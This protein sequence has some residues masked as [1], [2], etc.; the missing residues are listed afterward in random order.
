MQECG[1]VPGVAYVIAHP[2]QPFSLVKTI[3]PISRQLRRHHYGLVVLP[4]ATTTR[5][6]YLNVEF[7]ALP[8][9][10]ERIATYTPDGRWMERDEKQFIRQDLMT[11]L[12]LML[13]EWAD[14]PLLFM[15]LF[16]AQLLRPIRWLR[17]RIENALGLSR[18]PRK[19]MHCISSLGLGGAQRQM[20][21]VMKA[22]GSRYHV[23]LTMLNG[24]DQFFGA[25]LEK[26]RVRSRVLNHGSHAYVISALRLR[27]VLREEQIDVLHTWLPQANVVGALAGFLAGTPCVVTSE[28]NVSSNKLIWYPQWWFRLADALAA[29][30]CTVAST[31]AEAVRD[32]FARYTWTRRESVAVVYNGSQ[33]D[34][35]QILDENARRQMRTDLGISGEEAVVGIFGRLEPEKD[36]GTFLR[37]IQGAAQRVGNL[38]A[39]V[40]GGGSL[41]TQVQALAGEFQVSERVQFLGSRHDATSL[42]QICDLVV[43]T[44][45][46]EGMPNALLEAQHLGIAAVTTDAGGSGEVVQHGRTGFVVPIGDHASLAKYIERL[47]TNPEMLAGFGRAARRRIRTE[48]TVERTVS[49]FEALYLKKSLESDE[50]VLAA[51]CG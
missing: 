14:T 9:R 5:I 46:S 6:E 7:A 12:F 3:L 45:T 49:G 21:K 39:L 24:N 30:L 1:S 20:L 4:V 8:L 40:V 31:N 44:S 37:A 28:R 48:F 13:A 18:T 43:L 22:L 35:F 27:R 15:L 26:M 47:L 2:E 29:R 17:E 10:F 38:R 50:A 16:A 23:S 36:H 25:E 51:D 11:S 32:D 19:I 33:D 34:E 42:M 41:Q